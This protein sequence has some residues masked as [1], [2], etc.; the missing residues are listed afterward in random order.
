M[1]VSKFDGHEGEILETIAE[2]LSREIL[3]RD[4]TDVTLLSCEVLFDSYYQ[5]TMYGIIYRDSE[6]R[7]KTVAVYVT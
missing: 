6:N 1:V 2:E 5:P 7:L 4:G 3:E